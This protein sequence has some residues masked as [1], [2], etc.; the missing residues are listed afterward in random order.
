MKTPN[1]GGDGKRDAATRMLT[2]AGSNHDPPGVK[3]SKTGGK[4]E[5]DVKLMFQ[6]LMNKMDSMEGNIQGELGALKT[7]VGEVRAVAGKAGEMA[8]GAAKAVADLRTDVQFEVKR[9]D[10]SVVCTVSA[11]EEAKEGLATLQV[12]LTKMREGSNQ[13]MGLN[14]GGTTLMTTNAS[15][16]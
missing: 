8:E 6:Q 10:E 2:S 4:E 15:G 16:T 1:D 9:I 12:E 11:A 3:F 5:G 14:M 7:V 13:V